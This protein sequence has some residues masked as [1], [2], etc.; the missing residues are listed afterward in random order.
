MYR[1]PNCGNAGGFR[2]PCTVHFESY[3]P[4]PPAANRTRQR[5]D[6]P[7]RQSSATHPV[8]APGILYPGLA[9]TGESNRRRAGL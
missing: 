7:R 4:R 1:L 2:R 5:R 6:L 8:E 3:F 9:L